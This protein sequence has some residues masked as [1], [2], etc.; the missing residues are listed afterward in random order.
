M[1]TYKKFLLYK[2]IQCVNVSNPVISEDI[3]VYFIAYCFSVLKLKYSTIKLYLCGIRHF[4]V[5]KGISCPLHNVSGSPN[6]RIM[7]FLKSVKRN[8]STDK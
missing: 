1:T 4:Y 7:T 2:N 5:T 6:T 8:Q 3:I